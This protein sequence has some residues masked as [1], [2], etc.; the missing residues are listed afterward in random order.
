MKI[1]YNIKEKVVEPIKL[2]GGLYS[3]MSGNRQ[4]NYNLLKTPFTAQLLEDTF[5]DMFY[6]KQNNNKN[7]I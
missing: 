6:G 4:I 1:H 3:Q 5:R 2:G 7:A